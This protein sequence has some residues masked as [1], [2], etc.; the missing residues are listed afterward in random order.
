MFNCMAN[1]ATNVFPIGNIIIKGIVICMVAGSFTASLQFTN[2]C[3]APVF[4]KVGTA[5]SWIWTGK[6][7]RPH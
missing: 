4:N 7:N 5:N 1:M 6:Y 2:N 3:V